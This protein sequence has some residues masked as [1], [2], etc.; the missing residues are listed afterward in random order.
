MCTTILISLVS[1]IRSTHNSQSSINKSAECAHNKSIS[2]EN[3]AQDSLIFSSLED[4]SPELNELSKLINDT[5]FIQ[6]KDHDLALTSVQKEHMLQVMKTLEEINSWY[7]E[8]KKFIIHDSL[9][10]LGDDISKLSPLKILETF[11]ERNEYIVLLENFRILKS[12]TRQNILLSAEILCQLSKNRE[13]FEVYCEDYKFWFSQVT[14]YIQKFSSK[15][16]IPTLFDKFLQCAS[17]IEIFEKN[18]S[19]QSLKNIQSIVNN[20]GLLAKNSDFLAYIDL[21]RKIKSLKSEYV[22]SNYY[23]KAA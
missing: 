16:S 13:D 12:K 19:F 14:E 3:R 1:W 17:S 21:E 18:V 6:H 7:S 20:A 5:E 10:K 9:I 2:N 8:N 4:Y 15:G 11:G 22:I 23:N